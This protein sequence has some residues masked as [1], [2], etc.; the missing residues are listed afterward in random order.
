[1]SSQ[2]S[3]EVPS[4]SCSVSF[5][6]SSP[7]GSLGLKLNVKNATLRL[8]RN[9]HGDC[10]LLVLDQKLNKE[11]KRFC[12]AKNHENYKLNTKFVC[13][14]KCS[15]LI[16]DIHLR[17]FI[18]NCPPNDLSLFLKAF[19]LKCNYYSNQNSSPSCT[20]AFKQNIQRSR[21][22]LE[23]ISPIT[24]KDLAK[25]I[26]LKNKTNV[27]RVC[28]V[29]PLKSNKRKLE[30]SMSLFVFQSIFLC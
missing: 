9:A 19:T 30:T 3:L 7:N 13:E 26:A 11:V 21:S 17:L 23:D 4:I 12:F 1:M 2:V 24:S 18:C 6:S 15:I 16:C 22:A 20:A 27:S 8:C 14:G 29:I 25:N 5:E 10:V 28:S